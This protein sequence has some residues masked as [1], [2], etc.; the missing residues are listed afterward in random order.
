VYLFS[1]GGFP[2]VPGFALANLNLNYR[3]PP[4]PANEDGSSD[5]VGVVRLDASRGAAGDDPAGLTV[6]AG[7][8]NYRGSAVPDLTVRLE[9]LDAD[10]RPASGYARKVT[11][12]P[13]GRQPDGGQEVVFVIPDIPET[14]EAVLRVRLES[15]GDVFPLDDVA[16]LVPGVARKARVL[17]FAPDHPFERVFPGVR[18]F[19]DLPSTR[20]IAEVT[21]YTPERIADKAAYLDPVRDGKYDLVIFD[22]CGPVREDEMPR[23]NTLFV[24]FPPPPFR[25]AGTPDRL[26]VRPEKNPRVA[27]WLGSHPAVRRL[28]D[29]YEIEI[30]EAFRLPELP[31]RTDRVLE[32]DGNLVL[33]AGIPRP[34]FTD[35]VLTFPVITD[36]GKYNSLWPFRPSFILFLRNVVRT[37]GNVRDALADDVTRPGDLK[38]LWP[39]GVR[40]L[41]VTTPGGRTE[42]L[43][44]GTRP[45]FVFA[46]TDELG[47][48]TAAG[49][50]FRQRFAVNLFDP[51]E[52]DLAPRAAVS[53]GNQTVEAGEGRKRPRELWKLAVLGG[54]LVLLT[55]WWVYNRRVQI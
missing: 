14:V 2:P 17:V 24:G 41:R 48:Y 27:G 37:Y 8:R 11:L 52:G 38:P 16:W 44:R 22:R 15:T 1:D 32:S 23:A 30:D 40:K 35:L 39:G 18:R 13:K 33:L 19:L 49:G 55:E 51:A 50:D 53:V 26:A 21:R 9:V 3:T 28:R 6:T 20:R 12:E 25:P 46:G 5:N 4:A 7:V 29:L 31:P 45:D 43:D 36:D 34:P 42:E 47:V 10:G 54:L